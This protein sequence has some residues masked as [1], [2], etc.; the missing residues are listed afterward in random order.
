MSTT[1]LANVL[2]KILGLSFFI[3]GIT[4]P[5]VYFNRVVPISAVL[6][7]G[8]GIYLMNQSKRVTTLLFKNDDE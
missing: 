2:I 1:Q 4:H 6:M 7:A 8:I 3:E 5:T